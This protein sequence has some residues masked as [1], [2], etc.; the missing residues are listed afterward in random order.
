MSSRESVREDLT[1][2]GGAASYSPTNAAPPADITSWIIHPDWSRVTEY[3]IKATTLF[4]CQ[5]AIADIMFD[6]DETGGAA[7]FDIPSLVNGAWR[8]HGKVWRP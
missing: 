6:L 5:S 8:A 1:V 2:Q 4:A 3:E 7:D